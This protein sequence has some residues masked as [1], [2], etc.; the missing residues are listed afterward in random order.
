MLTQREY[1]S[2]YWTND[3]EGDDEEAN[4]GWGYFVD[5]S[6]KCIS[7]NSLNSTII[8]E[9]TASDIYISYDSDYDLSLIHI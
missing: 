1:H 7:N 4:N 2:E 5:P 9:R 3:K 8:E 6:H